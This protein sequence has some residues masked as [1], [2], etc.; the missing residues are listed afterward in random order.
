M[1]LITL[2]Q[3]KKLA[4]HENYMFPY[5]QQIEDVHEQLAAGAQPLADAGQQVLVVAHVLE[6]FHRDAAVVGGRGQRQHVH[7]AG[8]DPHV[9][10]SLI[11]I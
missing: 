6:H 5:H 11:H 8:D 9:F 10:L 1:E 4:L 7:V 2:A 3:A